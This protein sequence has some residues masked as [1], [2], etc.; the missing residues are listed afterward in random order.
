MTHAINLR[1]STAAALGFL[2][3]LLGPDHYLPFVAMSRA[4]RRST[5]KTV[6]IT[7]LCGL[8]H[9][10]SSFLLGAVGIAFGVGVLRLEAFEG[11]RGDLVGWLL[12]TF[13]LVYFT[14]GVH[15]AIRNKPHTHRHVHAD[16]SVHEHEHTHGGEHLHVHVHDDSPA[17]TPWV[18]FTI[19]LLG[20]C[21]PLS[22]LLRYPAAKGR[23][24]DVVLV[25]AIFG[26]T[27]LATVTVV[28]LL[29][30]SALAR[31][32]FVAGGLF[33]RLERYSHAVAG[34]VVLLCGAGIK[35]GL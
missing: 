6:V 27:T 32:P 3:T 5:S 35:A 14:W 1:C 9:V 24:W 10:L 34:F 20:P 13:G 19:F 11:F 33:T 30:H 2:H 22:P 7:L 12:L 29:A 21:E 16:G 4:W 23:M 15:R 18:L 25:T 17:H 8:G 31:L 26:I 28:V